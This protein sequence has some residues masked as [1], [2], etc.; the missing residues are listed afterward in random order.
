MIRCYLTIVVVVQPV[1]HS[2]STLLILIPIRL[3][4][5]DAITCCHILL[6]LPAFH[7]GLHYAVILHVGYLV[8]LIALHHHVSLHLLTFFTLTQSTPTRDSDFIHHHVPYVGP[9]YDLHHGDVPVCY[10]TVILPHDV[11]PHGCH[12][13]HYVV[14]FTRYIRAGD[15]VLRDCCVYRYLPPPFTIRYHVV[16]GPY[17]C[18]TSTCCLPVPTLILIC[19]LPHSTT[20][21]TLSRYTPASPPHT[22]LRWIFTR[23]TLRY[24]FILIPTHYLRCHSVPDLFVVTLLRLPLRFT[25]YSTFV[26]VV[27]PH[28]GGD[29]VPTCSH[30]IY[31]PTD[32]PF[33]YCS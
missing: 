7:S 29:A 10:T 19:L 16:H 8:R 32:S 13:V 14:D 30:A 21:V 1:Y 2:Q 15:Y 27:I 6:F 9:T 11:L 33:G 4:P 31:R 24:D 26:A 12:T 28:S 25:R 3:F 5:F 23:F 17:V 20:A 22:D 18:L